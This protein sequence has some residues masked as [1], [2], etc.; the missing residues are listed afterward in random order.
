MAETQVIESKWLRQC[1]MHGGIPALLV[2]LEIMEKMER[3]EECAEI[4]NVIKWVCRG[5]YPKEWRLTF[6]VAEIVH[7]WRGGE[8][9]WVSMWEN[10]RTIL[11]NLGI[12]EREPANIF[13]F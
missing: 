5:H 10:A 1:A 4:L 13:P 7:S 6:E 2:C 3:Y 11:R 12:K 8:F 9:A